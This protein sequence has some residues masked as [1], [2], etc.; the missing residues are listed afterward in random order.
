MIRS[1]GVDLV[2]VDRVQKAV[3]RWGDR[4]LRR[5]YTGAEVDYCFQKGEKYRSLAARFA[6]KEAVMKALGTGWKRGVR[7][8]DIEVVR[9]PGAAPEI[10]LHGQ[11]RVLGRDGRFLV[12]L[13]HT[14]THAIA[15]V[16]VEE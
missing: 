2:E 6:A 8:V 9:R 16:V 3:E 14:H 7:W 1:V 12:S 4:F 5:V 10:A 11:S 13:S 15:V